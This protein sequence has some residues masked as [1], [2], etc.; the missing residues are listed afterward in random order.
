M[1]GAL[2]Q[3]PVADT[4]DAS[5][6]D[7]RRLDEPSWPKLAFIETTFSGDPTNWWVPN[8]AGVLAMLAAAGFQVDAEPGEEMFVCHHDAAAPRGWWDAREFC[9]ARGSRPSAGERGGP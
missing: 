6:Q 9:A 3:P 1:G 7:R 2:K 5:F 8:R 4:S